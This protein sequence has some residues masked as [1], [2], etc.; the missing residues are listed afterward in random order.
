MNTSNPALDVVTPKHLWVVGV[1][2]L[3]WNSVGAFD[4]V[5]TQ[6]RNPTYM[7]SFTPDQL[8]YFYAFPKWV[9]AAW[10]LAVWGGVLGAVLLLL[11]KRVAVPIF[12]ASLAAMMLTSYYNFVLSSGLAVMGREAAI[13]SA[14]I[15]VIAV[16]LLIYSHRL[17]RKG[18]LR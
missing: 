4:Y 10:A 17:A 5:M 8:A 16:A 14:V 11:R 18:V 3:L 9:V 12:G 13:F 1:L 15:F 6:T 7:S 2:A